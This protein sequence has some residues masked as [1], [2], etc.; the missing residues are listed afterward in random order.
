MEKKVDKK[1]PE[2]FKK[3]VAQAQ[4]SIRKKNE[5]FLKK[6]V[7]LLFEKILY[8]LKNLYHCLKHRSKSK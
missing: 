2:L 4:P 3:K 6:D 1:N 5:I 7:V 8:L